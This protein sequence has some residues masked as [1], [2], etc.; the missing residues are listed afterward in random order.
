M[1][2]HVNPIH[3]TSKTQG[4]DLHFN[5]TCVLLVSSVSNQRTAFGI[6]PLRLF[7][8]AMYSFLYQTYF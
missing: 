8:A 1:I 5:N 2:Y 7:G 4:K 3:Y 6:S